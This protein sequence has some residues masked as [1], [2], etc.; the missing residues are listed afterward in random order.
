[1]HNLGPLQSYVNEQ[2]PKL[3]TIDSRDLSGM[4]EHFTPE[5]IVKQSGM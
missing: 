3:K 2:I 4:F 1:M 5:E